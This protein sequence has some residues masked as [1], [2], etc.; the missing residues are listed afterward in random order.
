[1]E[2]KIMAC[3]KDA[4]VSGYTGGGRI[5]KTSVETGL[6]T[7]LSNAFRAATQIEDAAIRGKVLE[8]ISQAQIFGTQLKYLR[9]ITS[10]EPGLQASLSNAFRAAAQIED[11]AVRG[12]VLESISQAQ[13]FDTQ[14]KYLSQ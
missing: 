4:I 3:E 2:K 5:D 12:K 10:A 8:S 7:S 14:L 1:M 9:D 6:E 11:A 13:I